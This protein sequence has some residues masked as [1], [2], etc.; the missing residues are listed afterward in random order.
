MREVTQMTVANTM[1]DIME[2]VNKL[3]SPDNESRAL[4]GILEGIILGILEVSIVR[5]SEAY[6]YTVPATQLI[7]ISRIK[8]IC[9]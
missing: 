2:E 5:M 9:T 6:T 1:N 8:T 7:N 3:S 4:L